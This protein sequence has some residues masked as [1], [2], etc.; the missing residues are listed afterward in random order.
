[1]KKRKFIFW[2]FLSILLFLNRGVEG[3]LIDSILSQGTTPKQSFKEVIPDLLYKWDIPGAAVA[4]VRNERL[5]MAEGYGLANKN[6]I[7]FVNSESLF[8]IA[9]ISKTITAVTILKMVEDGLLSLDDRAFKI[10]DNF[11]AKRYSS[12]DPRIYYIT[13]RDL[14]QHSGG[15]DP[16]RS[17]LYPMFMSYEIAKEMRVRGPADTSDIIRYMMGQPLDFSPGGRYAYSNF[18]YCVLGRIIEKITGENYDDYLKRRILRPIGIK[19]MAIGHTLLK[20]RIANEVR[21]YDYPGASLTWSVFPE[22]TY[23]VPWPY[24]GFYQEALDSCGGW[25]A[26]VVDL[27]RYITSVDNRNV[28]SDILKPAMIEQMVSRPDLPDWKDNDWYY[29][30][31]W[32]VRPFGSGANW[33]HDGSLP[34]TDTILVRLSDGISYAVLFNSSP[35]DI[36]S[37]I[38]ESDDA[39]AEAIGKITDWPF[40][41]LFE[42]YP[43]DYMLIISSTSG[44]KTSP[45]PG[46]QYYASGTK[47][48]I[49][50]TPNMK[51]GF[52]GWTGHVQAGRKKENPVTVN[53]NSYHSIKANFKLIQAPSNFSGKQVLNRSLFQA[54][55]INVLSWNSNSENEGLDIAKYRIYELS[56]NQKTLLAELNADIFE[57]NHRN[58]DKDKQYSYAIAGVTAAGR[59]GESVIVNVY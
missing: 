35:Y 26:S 59:E 55:Y 4:L 19:K 11:Q 50:A 39:V 23:S 31:G 43:T 51:Y 24:G 21:Y 48:S 41:D 49:K 12:V 57:Y 16:E 34:G 56:G 5:V 13:I 18:G 44:G 30:L 53:M 37:F 40:H 14:L 7:K 9:S 42:N 47:V 36:Y 25:I 6:N 27:M 20:D 10:L 52:T 45:Q 54:E 28:R 22:I 38:R 15:W 33:W 32:I 29:G 8:R 2:V 17:W 58:V 1:M 3:S 46:K